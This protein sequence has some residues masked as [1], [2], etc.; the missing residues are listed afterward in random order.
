[1][2]S[3]LE[4]VTVGTGV[5]SSPHHHK[6]LTNAQF[7][8]LNSYPKAPSYSTAAALGSELGIQELSIS[9]IL[10]SL[11]TDETR[12]IIDAESDLRIAYSYFGEMVEVQCFAL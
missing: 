1:M 4:A 12:S 8:I 9:Q 5:V 2:A 6:N 7:L 11:L 10:Q 3:A